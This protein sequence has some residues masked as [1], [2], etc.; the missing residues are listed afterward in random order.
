MWEKYQT[1]SIKLYIKFFGLVEHLLRKQK[2][3][4]VF[5]WFL[6]MMLFYQSRHVS[7]QPGNYV[8]LGMI[9]LFHSSWVENFREESS[10]LGCSLVFG[11][12]MLL[13]SK[14]SSWLSI[15]VVSEEWGDTLVGTTSCWISASWLTLLFDPLLDKRERWESWCS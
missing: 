8:I 13:C 14:P 12:S 5:D 1:I 3:S 11:I 6:G 10:V 9:L 2:M 4:L 7:N 15:S